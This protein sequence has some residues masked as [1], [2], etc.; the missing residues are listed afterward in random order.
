MT[1][2]IISRYRNVY[3][4]QNI[5]FSISG[6]LWE[7]LTYDLSYHWQFLINEN[8]ISLVF[9]PWRNSKY[10][11]I[12]C[13]VFWTNFEAYFYGRFLH[14]LKFLAAKNTFTCPLSL[15]LSVTNLNFSMFTPLLC[16]VINLLYFN[17]SK[18]KKIVKNRIK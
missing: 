15:C 4:L 18:G 8:T 3:C 10:Y 11:T 13:M 17:A 6:R 12:H 5:T 9:P 16:T 14:N 7:S 2:F 1:V